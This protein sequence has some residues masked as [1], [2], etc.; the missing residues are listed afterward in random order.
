MRELVRFILFSCCYVEQNKKEEKIAKN[1]ETRKTNTKQGNKEE[2]NDSREDV[3]KVKHWLRNQQNFLEQ[4]TH[5]RENV[6][7]ENRQISSSE[8]Y[9][10]K[11][12]NQEIV[13]NNMFTTVDKP[14]QVQLIK[15][16]LNEELNGKE[17]Q[18]MRRVALL[19]K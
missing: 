17:K 16:K 15:H 6:E 5:K 19:A 10:F 11:R 18:V 4:T 2:Q 9:A 14:V 13:N 12:L 1:K 7:Q 3:E 8:R